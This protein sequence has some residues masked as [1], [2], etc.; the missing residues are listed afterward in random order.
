MLLARIRSSAAC[1]IGSVLFVAFIAGALLAGSGATLT[2][3][4]P[5]PSG[6]DVAD[7][8]ARHPDDVG[9]HFRG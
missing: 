9:H 6:D 3:T 4:T 1:R 8:V 2:R 5:P 7:D